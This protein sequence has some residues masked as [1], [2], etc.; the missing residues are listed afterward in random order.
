VN[1]AGLWIFTRQQQRDEALV[2]KVRHLAAGKGFDLSVLNDVD[3]THCSSTS[4]SSDSLK[5]LS[6]AVSS[7]DDAPTV[8]TNSQKPGGGSGSGTYHYVSH[9][10]TPVISSAEVKFTTDD[11]N[12]G[13]EPT[14]SVRK[15]A[16]SLGDDEDDAGHIYAN[17]LG[18]LATPINIFPQSPHI[19]RGTY[20]SFE[21]KIYN[22]MK[23]GGASSGTLNWSFKYSSTSE[24]RPSG[25]TYKASFDAGCDDME[26]TFDNPHSSSSA[27]AAYSSAFMA[28]MPTSI[29]SIATLVGQQQ[30]EQQCPTVS[31]QPNFDLDTYISKRWYI[32]QQ[33]A[34]KYLP[35][36]QNYCVYAEYKKLAKP[37]FFGY[38]VQVHNYAQ[39]ADGTK[40]DS[41]DT[42]CAKENADAKDPAKLDVG[43][44]FLPRISGLSTGPYWVLA[45][46]E[47]EGYALV[48]GGQ[49][50]I[51]DGTA[52]CKT[53][54]GVNN[55]GL[56]I[57]TRQQ[58]RDEAL[59]QKVRH[60]AAVK[61]FDLSVLNDVDQS[62][63]SS[64]QMEQILV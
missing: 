2:Q 35:K 31:T 30:E 47:A 51:V 15:Y 43:P 44:C 58:K 13:T 59:V 42:I 37:S 4:S 39:E 36:E 63:C 60:L 24:T 53:G 22:C 27:V 56:W 62:H 11:L 26:E 6:L 46:S 28:A 29:N 41:K 49:P 21:I 12:T 7:D 48:S 20:R 10:G 5:T 50:T 57:F 38:T 45:Y 23:T 9:G 33:M 32:Q 18:G 17:E 55:A 25:V 61:G 8:G 64:S 19:N 16:R 14:E 40:H 34:V 3:Q 54:N 1:N 52:G